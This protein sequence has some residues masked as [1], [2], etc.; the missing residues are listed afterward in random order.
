MMVSARHQSTKYQ[1]KGDQP[2]N[3]ESNIPVPVLT[4]AMIILNHFS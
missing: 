3:V 4:I 1:K 2:V